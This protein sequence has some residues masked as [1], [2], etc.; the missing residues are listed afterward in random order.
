MTQTLLDASVVRALRAAAPV[1]TAD[2][3]RGSSQRVRQIR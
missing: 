2:T 1:L 3:S